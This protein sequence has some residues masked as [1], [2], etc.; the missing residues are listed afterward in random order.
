M[1]DLLATASQWTLRPEGFDAI[2]RAAPA[3]WAV[4][5]VRAP[6]VSDGDGGLPPSA[7][8]L[9]A[10]VTAEAYFGFGIAAPLLEAGRELR[11]VHTAAAGVGGLLA[12]A[13]RERDVLLT[14]SAGVHA[15]PI[16]EYVVGGVLYLLRSMDIASDQ[17][18]RG[19]W[20]RE[21]FVGGGSRVRELGECRALIVGAGGIGTEIARRLAAFGARCTGVRRR[22]EQGAPEGFERVV[23]PDAL[24]RELA[25][26]DILILSAPATEGTRAL[27]GAGEL[28]MLPASA[29]VVNIARGALLDE[30]ALAERVDG[31]RLRGAVLDVFREEPLPPDSRLWRSRA[32]VLTPHVSAVSPTG[33]WRRELELFVHNWHCYDEGR[34]MRNVV[35]KQAGY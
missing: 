7:D 20:D 28:D 14:N 6:T 16:A 5:V 24:H 19:V 26:A 31:G 4:H 23:A 21:P 18:R 30:E 11:W 32:I 35:D 25:A 13:L 1:V 17:A 9:A 2:R 34:P 29:I 15:V 8:A 10:I 33:F 3:G 22:P 27:I 12:G